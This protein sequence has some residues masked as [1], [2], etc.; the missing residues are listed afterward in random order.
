MKELEVVLMY[1]LNLRIADLAYK[2][3]CLFKKVLLSVLEELQL[4]L[5]DVTNDSCKRVVIN[6]NDFKQ[7]LATKEVLWFT[8]VVY[9]VFSKIHSRTE[10]LKIV[11]IKV[12]NNYTIVRLKE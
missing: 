7:V 1:G 3:P 2:N 9:E 4:P 8:K 11:D 5:V 6:Q 12:F 10:E